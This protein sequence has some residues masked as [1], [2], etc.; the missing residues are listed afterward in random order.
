VA[1]AHPF[2]SN[3]VRVSAIAPDQFRLWC[4]RDSL[5]RRHAPFNGEHDVAPISLPG[6]RNHQINV[7]GQFTQPKGGRFLSPVAACRDRRYFHCVARDQRGSDY[8][9]RLNLIRFHFYLPPFVTV[10]VTE[11]CGWQTR[12]PQAAPAPQVTRA[13]CATDLQHNRH[14]MVLHALPAA[15]AM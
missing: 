2:P 7:V 1:H 14:Q 6:R 11:S 3:I 12:V 8:R 10:T 4:Q 13:R 9:S 15:V 5:E